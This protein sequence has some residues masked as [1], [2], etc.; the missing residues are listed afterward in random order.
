[1]FPRMTDIRHKLEEAQYFFKQMKESIDDD[2]IF[3]F[4]L[5]AFLTAARSISLFM[6]REFIRST[7]RFDDWYKTYVNIV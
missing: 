5:S 3:S 1:M 7:L 4:N 2:E 6:Q